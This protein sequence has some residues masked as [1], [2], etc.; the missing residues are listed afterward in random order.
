M[1]SKHYDHVGLGFSHQ[2]MADRIT[3]GSKVLEVGCATGYMTR[4]LK[5]DLNCSVTIVEID[6][7]QATQASPYADVAVVGDI[8][9]A[10]TWAKIG[11]GYDAVLFGDVLEHLRDPW[12]ILR[13]TLRVLGDG[14]R[15]LASIPNVA[16]YEVRLGLLRGR[17]DYSDYGILDNTHLRFFTAASARRLFEGVG[18][19]IVRF[20]PIFKR[21]RHRL[22]GRVFR[23]ACAFQFVIEAV[24]KATTS[25]DE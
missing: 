3:P 23:N 22:L 6:E 15:V 16:Y 13:R 5:E 7:A 11:S 14:G 18:Y 2:A 25:A 21:A 19:E 4:V 12:E 8:E 9:D 10:G 24:P 17:F 20:R 1:R